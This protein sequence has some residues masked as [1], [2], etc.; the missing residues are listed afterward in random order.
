MPRLSLMKRSRA[1]EVWVK[2]PSGRPLEPGQVIRNE[3][4]GKRML[5]I[6]VNTGWA[7]VQIL[8][9]DRGNM[10]RRIIISPTSEVDILRKS[11]DNTSKRKTG[12]KPRSFNPKQAIIDR[13]KSKKRRTGRRMKR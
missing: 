4:R 10:G 11:G 3:P 7:T 6:S 5:V 1:D 12:R 9:N 8:K 2:N 13:K